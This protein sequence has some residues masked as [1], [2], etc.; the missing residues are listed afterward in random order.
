MSNSI[1]KIFL[2]LREDER[3]ATL[4]EYGVALLVAIIAG[5]G[6]LITLADNTNSNFSEANSTIQTR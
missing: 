1:R 3:G 4:V 5:G 6:F 2:K